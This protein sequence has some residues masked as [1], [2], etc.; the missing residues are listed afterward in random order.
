MPRPSGLVLARRVV[1]GVLLLVIGVVVAAVV[2]AR[3]LPAIGVETLTITGSSMEPTIPKG[4]VVLLD[5]VAA[6]PGVGEI[7]SIDVPGGP[8]YTHRVVGIVEGA[9][10]PSLQTKGDA[11][12]LPDPSLVRPDWVM[13]RVESS[14]PVLGFFVRLL[15][16][17][18]GLLAIL[19]M[20]IL[21]FTTAMLLEDLEW[22]RRSRHRR[23]VA[24]TLAASSTAAP[25][26]PAAATPARAAERS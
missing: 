12:A 16:V 5:R 2:V 4:S 10:G 15:S 3:L 19:S 18:S 26:A 8:T 21:L 9:D 1:D 22:E 24:A 11:N 13:G 14:V 23:A 17:P 25:T 20:S 6:V 7:V